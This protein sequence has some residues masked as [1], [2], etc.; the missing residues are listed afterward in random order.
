MPSPHTHD[1]AALIVSFS[2][3][4]MTAEKGWENSASELPFSVCASL[5]C[6]LEV[7]S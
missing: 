3:V 2:L 1:K 7:A 6:L 5:S 4:L